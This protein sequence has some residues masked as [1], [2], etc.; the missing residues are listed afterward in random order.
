MDKMGFVR[1]E[2]LLHNS[3]I[4]YKYFDDYICGLCK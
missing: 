3:V 2:C 1:E 4:S